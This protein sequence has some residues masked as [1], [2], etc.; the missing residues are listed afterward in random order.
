MA[1]SGIGSR[2][3]VIAGQPLAV[4]AN[5]QIHCLLAFPDGTATTMGVCGHRRARKGRPAVAPMGGAS[6][7][8]FAEMF[9]VGG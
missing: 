6:F 9:F 5:L 1:L 2:L 4:V 7:F 3:G 8:L